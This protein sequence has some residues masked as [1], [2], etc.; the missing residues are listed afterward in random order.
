MKIIGQLFLKD[1]KDRACS[2]KYM[3]YLFSIQDDEMLCYASIHRVFILKAEKAKSC[4]PNVT[5]GISKKWPNVEKKNKLKKEN[6][7]K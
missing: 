1:N 6:S 5:H 7:K 2:F 4:C 3:L